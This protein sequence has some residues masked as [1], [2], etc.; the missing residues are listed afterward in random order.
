MSESQQRRDLQKDREYESRRQNKET[1][2]EEKTDKDVSVRESFNPP[3]VFTKTKPTS[4]FR[5]EFF[6][7]PTVTQDA[8]RKI[9]YT[10]HYTPKESNITIN[11]G[12]EN[13]ERKPH[14]S[15][16]KLKIPSSFNVPSKEVL[17]L[18]YTINLKNNASINVSSQRKI[19]LIIPHRFWE[20]KRDNLTIVTEIKLMNIAKEVSERKVMK[21]IPTEFWKAFEEK[22]FINPTIYLPVSNKIKPIQNTREIVQLE[23]TPEEVLPTE[24]FE[25]DEVLRGLSKFQCHGSLVMVYDE[26]KQKI[27][28]SLATLGVEMSA[29]CGEELNEVKITNYS[30][31]LSRIKIDEGVFVLE[32]DICE[33]ITDE[34]V[35]K[36]MD[37]VISSLTGYKLTILVIPNCLYE[38]Y[39]HKL[40]MVVKENFTRDKILTLAYLASGLDKDVVSVLN[41]FESLTAVFHKYQEDVLSRGLNLVLKSDLSPL[42]KPGENESSVHKSL[43]AIILLHLVK[44]MN[45]DKKFIK[46]EEEINGYIPDVY[47]EN[48]KMVYDAKTSF[49][50]HPDDEIRNVVTKYSSF[51]SKIIV[52]MRP[53]PVLINLPI[54]VNLLKE[55]R[56]QNIKVDVQ[57][58][59]KEGDKIVLMPLSEFIKK[60]KEFQK[61]GK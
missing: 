20:A 3:T 41:P 29:I 44:N 43:K 17:K 27:E 13:I 53:L 31:E 39:K 55:Y 14:L 60:G 11:R 8:Q 40:V 9:D 36:E 33:E 26:K 16:P 6:S 2:P 5:L 49:E 25:E 35:K 48:E 42:L 38:M 34:V 47:V 10:V 28:D 15:L 22:L 23:P 56:K 21:L 1:K 50:V 32:Q 37:A 61:R 12:V 4:T 24:D 7:P 19:K 46:V 45:I 57:I 51:A 30:Y 54:I 52:V 58:P 59:V 18:N